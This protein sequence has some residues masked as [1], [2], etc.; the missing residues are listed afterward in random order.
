VTAASQA[1]ALT[2]GSGQIV[3]APGDTLYGIAKAHQVTIDKLIG[4]NGL[5]NPNE[6]A[7]GQVLKIG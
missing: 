5:K 4:L 7:V 3:V 6:L 1:P 2:A